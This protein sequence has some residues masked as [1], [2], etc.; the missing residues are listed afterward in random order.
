VQGSPAAKVTAGLA[1]LGL[2][3]ASL[4]GLELALEAIGDCLNALGVGFLALG[5][6]A[7][8]LGFIEPAALAR[9][10]LRDEQ[11]STFSDHPCVERLAVDGRVAEVQALESAAGVATP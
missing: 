10:I 1:R 4:Q 8:M 7:R 9:S 2:A 11:R 3:E 6:G 5:V